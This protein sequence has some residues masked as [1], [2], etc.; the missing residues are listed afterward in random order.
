VYPNPV[1]DISRF[2]ITSQKRKQVSYELIDSRGAVIQKGT[3]SL[4]SGTNLFDMP[5]SQLSK[6]VYYL[7]VNDESGS[8]RVKGVKE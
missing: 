2:M 4:Q 8:V 5:V 7:A 3:Y 1:K 6:G